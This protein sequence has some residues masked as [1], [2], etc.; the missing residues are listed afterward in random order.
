LSASDR[1]RNCLRLSCGHPWSP[2]REQAI[3][4]LGQLIKAFTREQGLK[5]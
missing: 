1:Y 3:V 4:K 2:Q 5:G